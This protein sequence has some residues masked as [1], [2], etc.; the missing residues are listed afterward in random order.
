MSRLVSLYITEFGK[1]LKALFPALPP[2]AITVGYQKAI[3][4]NDLFIVWSFR[5]ISQQT[6]T[7]GTES[8]G[9]D[10][11][12]FALDIAGRRLSEVADTVDTIID[13]W[14]GFTGL[15]TPNLSVAKLVVTANDHAYDESDSFH[16]ISVDVTANINITA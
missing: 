4:V 11:P 5:N 3:S 16:I 8:R 2:N 10:K 7:G 13:S 12:I 14:Q 6:F 1:A 15:L 9:I